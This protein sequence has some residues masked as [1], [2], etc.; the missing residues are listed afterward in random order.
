PLAE[1]KTFATFALPTRTYGSGER[2]KASRQG[3]HRV[4]KAG[5]EA[6]GKLLEK[7]FAKRLRNSKLCLPLQPA[8]R[9]SALGRRR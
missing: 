3:G 9:G 1:K 2:D 4:K 8:S 7:T 6:S 5:L